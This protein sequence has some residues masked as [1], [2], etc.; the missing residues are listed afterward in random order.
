MTMPSFFNV[1]V[2][3]MAC[4]DAI[5][6]ISLSV[7]LWHNTACGVRHAENGIYMMINVS[8]LS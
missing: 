5:S 2:L 4:T 1:G 8:S 3:N 7:S 6:A